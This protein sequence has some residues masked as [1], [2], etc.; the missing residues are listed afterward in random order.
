MIKISDKHIGNGQQVFIIAEAGVNHD[1]RPDLAKKLVDYA[2]DAGAD[3]VK[4]QTYEPERL[5][6]KDA[7]KPDYQKK[8]IKNETQY[9]MLKRLYFSINDLSKVIEYGKKKNII[10]FSTPYDEKS[11]DNLEEIGVSVFKL[12]SIEVVNHPF[13]IHMAK[14]TC[15]P[16]G[17][18][19]TVILSTGLSTEKEIEEAV[20]IFRKYGDL[21]NLILLHCHVNYPSRYEDLNLNCI[22]SFIKKY[23]VPTG[24]SDHTA[25]LFIPSIAV[26]LGATVIEKHLTYDKKA[27]GPDHSSSLEP[28]E[29]REMV[30]LIRLTEK[31]LGNGI[32]MPSEEEKKNLIMRKSLVAAV[33]IKKGDVLKE[34]MLTAKRPGKGLFPTFTNINKIVGKKAV[35]DILPDDLISIKDIK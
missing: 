11:A 24:F 23:K 30:N 28:K 16:A 15:L 25:D 5:L 21:N 14:K 27:S 19:K 8:N 12:A 4:F 9:Q 33:N 31:S 7:E 32:R 20:D 10:V 29:F 2:K 35:K 1:G 6:R 3:A 13:L 18:N 17:R 26:A 34:Y 22:K